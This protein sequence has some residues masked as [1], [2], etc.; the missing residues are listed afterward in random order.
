MSYQ[1]PY[2]V[3]VGIV[4][5]NVA[6]PPILAQY[7]AGNAEIAPTLGRNLASC[8]TQAVC[9]GTVTN[10]P[11]IVPNTLLEDRRSQFDVRLSKIVKVR[12]MRL[13]GNFDVYN[14]F[15]ASSVLV[16]NTSYAT[17]NSQWLKPTAILP[18]RVLQVSASLSF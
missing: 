5:Q 15:N 14:L 13:Q 3:Q 17:A 16:I 10:I 12:N 9:T 1:L 8:G 4:Y 11:L 2:D 7:T 18:A 6:G